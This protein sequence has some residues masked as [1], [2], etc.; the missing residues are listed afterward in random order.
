MKTEFKGSGR[1]GRVALKILKI[2]LAVVTFP[3]HAVISG[4]MVWAWNFKEILEEAV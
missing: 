2:V 1:N 4:S 3:L